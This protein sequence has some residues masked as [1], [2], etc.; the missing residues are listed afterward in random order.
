[1]PGHRWTCKPSTA[2]DRQERRQPPAICRS[3]RQAMS[4]WRAYRGEP[5]RRSP[6]SVPPAGLV[7]PCRDNRCRRIGIRITR[8]TGGLRMT[9]G[10]ASTQHARGGCSRRRSMSNRRGRF[11]VAGM[12]SLCHHD[13]TRCEQR[14]A[15]RARACLSRREPHGLSVRLASEDAVASIAA[16]NAVAGGF[17]ARGQAGCLLAW[18]P[19]RSGEPATGWSLL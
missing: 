9:A 14:M 1:M 6:N 15:P 12:P 11:A 5:W 17:G 18:P 13:G 7:G 3:N 19:R 10:T 16:I 2:A 4:S 8:V